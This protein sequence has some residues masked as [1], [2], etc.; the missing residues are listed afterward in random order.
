MSSKSKIKIKPYLV[1]VRI[2]CINDLPELKTKGYSIIFEGFRK[3][4]FAVHHRI[5]GSDNLWVVTEM[6]SGIAFKGGFNTRLDAAKNAH[7]QLKTYKQ[8]FIK[9]IQKFQWQTQALKG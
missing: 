1:N 3:Y 8:K 7:L 5:K 2:R 4:K 6:S 9:K